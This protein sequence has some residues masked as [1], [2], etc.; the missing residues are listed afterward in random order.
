MIPVFKPSVDDEEIAAVREV[1]NSG[2]IGLGPKTDEFERKFSEYVGAP[3]AI[4][5]NSGTAAL[6]L[7]LKVLGIGEGDE[8]ILPS[9]TFVS[10]AHAVLYCGAVPVFADVYEDT[11]TMCVEDVQE[12]LTPRTRA[13]MP[14]HYGGHPCDMDPIMEI[15]N[16]KGAFVVEDAAH[17]CGAEYK[18]KRIGSI[19][20][21]TAFSFHAVKNLT[22][23]EGGMI[24]A[25]SKEIADKLRK[26]RWLGISKTTWDRYRPEGDSLSRP[27]ATWYYEVADLGYNFHMSDVAA[28]IGI[29]QL[30]KLNRSN[31]RRR[32]IAR[33]YDDSFHGLA[34]IQIPVEKDYAKSVYHLYVLKVEKRDEFIAHLG[35]NGVATSVHYMP[36]HLHPLYRKVST[37]T[38]PVTERIWKKLVTLPMFPDLSDSELNKIVGAVRSFA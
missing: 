34:G 18:G 24:T 28:A 21:L 1:L 22:T 11:L 33:H 36:I 23:G 2:W 35:K 30:K 10:C 15:A 8:V 37:G 9:L 25:R 29:V 3:Y 5:T 13:I 16:D 27:A 38:L 6:H 12:K 17:A 32:H 4:G 19:A 7:A 31:E 26:L 14:V 20:G